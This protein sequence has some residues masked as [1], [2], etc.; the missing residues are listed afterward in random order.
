[1]N[2]R[3]HIDSF[4]AVDLPAKGRR[5]MTYAQF[6]EAVLKAGRFS[7]FEATASDWSAGMFTALC[8]DPE[9]ETDISCGF[10]WTLVRLRH[11]QAGER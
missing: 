1:M 2:A 10:P 8:R 9:V 3:V 4:E 11:S 7:V 6:R 5:K